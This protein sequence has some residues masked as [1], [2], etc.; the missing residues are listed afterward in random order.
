MKLMRDETFGPVVGVMKFKTIEEA[1]ELANDSYLGLTA[2]IWT[3]NKKLAFKIA[4]QIEAGVITIND[5]LMSHGLAET[6]WGGF[7]MSGIGKTHGKMG[8]EEMVQHKVV[9]NDI[10]SFAKKSLD[11]QIGPTTSH[12]TTSLSVL[13]YSIF[14]ST[15]HTP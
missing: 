10:L 1:I 5:H 9:V 15:G 6:P 13:L 7:K 3:K 8:F 2:S 11:S 12:G 4:H 14:V